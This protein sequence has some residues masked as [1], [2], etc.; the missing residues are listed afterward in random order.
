MLHLEDFRHIVP[1]ATL[2]EIYAR[3]RGLYGKHVVHVNSTYTGGGVAAILESLVPLMNDVGIDAGWRILHGTMDFFELTKEFH[4]ALQGK[5][6]KLTPSKKKLYLEVNENFGRFTHLDHDCIIVH[7]PQPLPLIS[8]YTK[9]QP[10]IWRCHIDLSDPQ[11]DLWEYLKDFLIKYDQVIVSDESY[12]KPDLPVEQRLMRPAINPLTEKN[13]ELPES[14]MAA[15]LDE[16]NV[17]RDKPLVTQVSRLDPWKDPEGLL[18]VF[19]LV[20]KEIDCRLVF[21]YNVA[22]DDPEALRMYDRVFKKARRVAKEDEVL[23]IVGNKDTLVN[24]LQK[25]SDVIVQK[26]TREGFCLAVTEALWKGRPVVASRV[27]GIPSQIQDGETGFLIE[28]NDTEGFANR[29]VRLLAHPEEGKAIGERARESAR[30]KFLIPR[31]LSDYLDMLNA[32]I[33]N[34]VA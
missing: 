14:T 17:P 5:K 30:E 24:A 19:T 33:G 9:R 32:M 10:W 27:G 13:R 6:L 22:S 16:F 26:S 15:V 3:A 18:D 7:D 28:R 8:V 11:P 25:V 1:D 12:F 31:L 29:I 21:C 2:A 23:F 4:N 34:H 20:K